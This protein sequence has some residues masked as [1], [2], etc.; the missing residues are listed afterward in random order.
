VIVLWS[1]FSVGSDWVKEEAAEGARRKVLVPAL[2]DDVSIPLGFR[3]IQAAQLIA[4]QPDGG[5]PEFLQLLESVSQIIGTKPKASPSPP[6]PSIDVRPISP[7]APTSPKRKSALLRWGAAIATFVIVLVAMWIAGS[8]VN[9]MVDALTRG[10][11]VASVIFFLTLVAAP[12][13]ALV[14]AIVMW[15]RLR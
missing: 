13:I 7:N 2:I 15:R 12:V 1:R 10:S 6:V 14:L 11:G 5:D 4:W 8:I 3:R 9:L